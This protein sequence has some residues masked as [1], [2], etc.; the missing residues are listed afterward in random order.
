MQTLRGNNNLDF[1]LYSTGK[2]FLN[3]A[4]LEGN[5]LNLFTIVGKIFVTKRAELLLILVIAA[6]RRNRNASRV[7][8]QK[9]SLFDLPDNK[10][11]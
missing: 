5:I 8:E 6:R 1:L 2:E 4:Q 11:L 7:P 9:V 10:I 3:M